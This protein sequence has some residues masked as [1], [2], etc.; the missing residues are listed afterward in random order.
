MTAPITPRDTPDVIGGATLAEQIIEAARRNNVE[1]LDEVLSDAT[2]G[3]PEG[4]EKHRVESIAKLIN[5]ARDPLGNTALHIT[6]RNGHYEVM[7][8]ILDQEGVEVDPVNLLEGDTP[9]HCAV[10]Y[11][12]AGEPEHGT[13]IVEEL[14]EAG[15]DPRIKNKHQQKA[16]E[17]ISVPNEKLEEILAGAEFALVY[18]PK[19]GEQTQ[20][21]DPTPNESE[22]SSSESEN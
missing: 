1:L 8:Q 20:A 19:P 3:I 13:F 18:G 11:A 7:D 5:E 14:V 15:A 22:G 10:R 21:E 6:A 9:L 12:N 17:L 4:D 2:Q 16:V